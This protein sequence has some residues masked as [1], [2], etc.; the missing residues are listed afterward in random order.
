MRLSRFAIPAATLL[1]AAILCLLAA[2][3]AS[4]LVENTSRTEVGTALDMAELDWAEV[5]VNGLQVFLIGEAPDEA[6]RFEAV[7]VAGTVV[8]SARVIDQMLVAEPDDIRAPRFSVEILRNDEGISVIGL[9]PADTDREALIERFRGLVGEDGEVS[10]LLEVSD[11]PEPEGWDDALTFA[12]RSMHDLPR[13]KVSVEAGRVQIKAMTDS[14]RERRDLRADLERRA[15][16]GME[17]ALELSAPR[18]V[19]TPFTLRF[20]IDDDGARFDACSADTK[21][22]RDRI[23]AA[24]QDAGVGEDATCRLGLGVPTREWADAAVMGIEAVA[25]L[26]GGSVTFSNADVAL[27]AL[28]G[29]DQAVFDR[30]V[31]ELENGLPE[32]FALKAVLP[33]PPEEEEQGPPEFTATLSPEG[34]VQLRGRINSEISRQTA[35]SFAKARFG[36]EAVYTA[37]RVDDT[38]PSGWPARVLAG[39]EALGELS[40]GVVRVTPDLVSVAGNTGNSDANAVISG[41]LADKLGETADFEIEVTYQEKLDPTL[42]IPTPEECEAQIVDIIG[43]R[44]ITFE[45]GSANLDASAKDVMDDIAELLKLCGDIPL[46][47]QGHT[48]S[49]G[50][51]SMNQQL[52]QERAQS[53]LNALRNRMVLTASYRVTGYGE[54]Q[55]IADNDTEEGR[56][57]NR[58]IEFK[59]VR[60]EPVEEELTTLE[61]LEEAAEAGD[62]EEEGA[63]ADTAEDAQGTENGAEGAG[64]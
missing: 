40:N 15:P 10:D 52:S 6:A 54:E 23:L 29:T 24:A 19:I 59:L 4:R 3:F 60:P 49:Q 31:G 38:L 39:L 44:K 2:F 25:N 41:L 53:V 58:R 57:A 37:A 43:D 26:G 47:I 34:S 11:F 62:T 1:A 63:Q 50:R 14:D 20:L 21:A 5:D 64:E 12:E 30:V 16:E 7:T 32:V 61:Q 9:V 48:D 18:P 45:P 46:E 27:L 55:P 51:E 36:S 17:L 35:D 42:G 13:S 22:A 8:D 28:E 56:E 33:E